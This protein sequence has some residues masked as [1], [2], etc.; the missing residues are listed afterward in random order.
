MR[1]GLIAG[2]A[3][4][5][6]VSAGCGGDDDGGEALSDDEYAERFTEICSGFYDEVLEVVEDSTVEG[7]DDFEGIAEV[8]QE[9]QEPAQEAAD[10]LADLQP[11]DEIEDEAQELVDNF[12]ERVDLLDDTLD[13]AEG[14]DED[15]LQELT[16]QS[17]DLQA[18][19]DELARN[20]DGP[21]FPNSLIEAFETED[22]EDYVI[23]VSGFF[24]STGRFEVMVD[25]SL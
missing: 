9:T 1:R 5:A 19:F 12:Q 18:E 25:P 15:E 22:G 13:A 21:N 24:G 10:E 17:D 20:D 2:L 11:P 8:A 4:L 14:E 6:L 3:A 16:E 7:P 23:V